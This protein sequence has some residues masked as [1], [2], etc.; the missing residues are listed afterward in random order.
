MA[1][2]VRQHAFSPDIAD[3]FKEPTATTLWYAMGSDSEVEVITAA[4]A[5]IPLTFYNLVL[6]NI[7]YKN[8]GGNFW[9]IQATYEVPNYIDSGGGLGDPAEPNTPPAALQAPIA[10][11]ARVGPEFSADSGGGTIHITQS[12]FTAIRKRV[13]DAVGASTAKNHKGAINVTADGVQGCDRFAGSFEFTITLK[14]PFATWKYILDCDDLKD[15]VN[16]E[17]FLIFPAGE[18]LYR[19]LTPNYQ[20]GEG[21][22]LTHKFARS[23][24]ELTVVI[25]DELTIE[26]G[27]RLGQG[28]DFAKYGWEYLWIDYLPDPTTGHD[29]PRDVFIEQIYPYADFRVLGFGSP[30]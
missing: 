4:Q 19:G 30:P 21:W 23:K 14:A 27:D 16:L 3:G 8:R 12:N 18:I 10:D 29:K 6:K 11:D 25:N 24:N 20:S 17:E 5:T 22:T 7:S 26:A 9:D 28:L 13:G 2:E 15:C 1:A